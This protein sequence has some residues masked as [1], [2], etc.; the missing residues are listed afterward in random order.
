MAYLLLN[1]WKAGV[2]RRRPIYAL[3][4]GTIWDGIN[5]HISRGGDIE[6]RK[7]FVDLDEFSENTFGLI[8]KGDSLYTFGSDDPA[9]VTLPGGVLYQRLQHPYGFQMVALVTADLFGGFIFAIAR[10]A[11]GSTCVFY[12][13]VLVADWNDG[14]VRN[15]M[16]IIQNVAA[17]LATL[18]D[19]SA[20]FSAVQVGATV[21]VTSSNA[22]TPFTTLVQA[23]NGGNID[24]QAISVA[25][26]TANVAAVAGVLAG[27]SFQVT[28]GTAAGSVT[29]I[30]VNAVEILVNPVTWASSNQEFARL[31]AVEINLHTGVTGWTADSSGQFVG[32]HKNVVGV[33]FNGLAV[34]GTSAVDVRLDGKA[35]GVTAL[36]S[37]SGGVDAVAAGAQVDTITLSGTFDPGDS[38]GARMTTQFES[39]VTEYFGNYAKPTGVPTVCRTLKRKM[40]VGAGPL[41]E[42][43]QVND[44]T[45]WN[46]DTDPGAGFLNASTHVG[47]SEEVL[48]L[49]PYQGRLAV[50]SRRAIQLWLMQNDDA[51]NDLQQVLENTGSRSPR[52]ILEYAG[53][54]VFY[55]DDTGIRSLRARDAS[56]NAYLADVGVAIDA[57][58]RE[59]LRTG[60]TEEEVQGAA[61][62]IEPVDGRFMIAIGER[63]FVYS[64]FPTSKVAAW[65]WYEPGFTAEW[66]VRTKTKVYARSG[67]TLY[68]YGGPTGEAYEVGMAVSVQL[69]YTTAGKP[70]TFRNITAVN[71]AATGSWAVKLHVDPNDILQIVDC[72]TNVGVTFDKADWAAVGHCT[73]LAPEF[74]HTGDGNY[75]SISNFAIAYS[76]AEQA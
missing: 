24:N 44:A 34:V 13:G 45:G 30:T 49:C 48:G 47:G 4:P 33:A 67:N 58:I 65:T 27:F 55:L 56:N 73:H 8:A 40:Y 76:G 70:G 19:A 63:I 51:L 18:I 37:T 57:L 5:C 71:M 35:V 22:G 15:G 29:S 36:G 9:M 61:A 75:A 74:T 14:V 64:Y 6:I 23:I 60:A 69:P 11:E 68:L 66:L 46:V 41:L 53:N 10:Y 38:F 20:N 31:L 62:V 32:L 50:F 43:S 12:N 3:P 28:A 54:D 39:P 1:D 2:D 21:V 42:F 52:S 26:T 17:A 72:G 16:G 7:A 59:W 25:T